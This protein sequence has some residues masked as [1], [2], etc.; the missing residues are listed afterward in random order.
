MSIFI[1]WQKEAIPIP[2]IHVTSKNQYHYE[3]YVP[4]LCN[5]LKLVFFLTQMEF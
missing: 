2:N 1:T 4:Y 5:F 3:T